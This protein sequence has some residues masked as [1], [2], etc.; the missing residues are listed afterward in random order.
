MNTH[1]LHIDQWAGSSG[2]HLVA[3][4]QHCGL[5]LS[6]LQHYACLQR[7]KFTNCSCELE[8]AYIRNVTVVP[9]IHHYIKI[10][11]V[12]PYVR[13][14][15][16]SRNDL[17]QGAVSLAIEQQKLELSNHCDRQPWH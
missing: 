9:Y 17:K 3:V 7:C 12:R 11:V 10:I 8:Y 13:P 5:Q 16:V 4:Y 1:S 14:S 2:Q 15:F 6:F